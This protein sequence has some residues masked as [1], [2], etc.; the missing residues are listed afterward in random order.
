MK[1]NDYINDIVYCLACDIE[2]VN[3][4]L[5]YDKHT[6]LDIKHCCKKGELQ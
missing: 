2:N 3:F 5:S 6:E 1:L 4:S